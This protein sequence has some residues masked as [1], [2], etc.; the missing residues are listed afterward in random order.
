MNRG[1][2]YGLALAAILSLGAC[3]G[4]G[5]YTQAMSGHFEL[6]RARQDIDEYLATA[7]LNDPLAAR[8]Q[9][10]REITA[11]SETHLDLPADGSYEQFARLDRAAVT[12]NV[13]AAPE[14]SLEPKTWCFLV[15]GCVP[16]RGY[17]E[18]E[19]AERLAVKLRSKGLDVSVT[20][21]AAYSTLGWFDDPLLDTVLNQ[22]DSQLAGTLI[23]ELAHQRLYVRGD[24]AFNESYAAFVEQ[25]GVQQWL[26]ATGR[27]SA[28]Q[29]W[30]RRQEAAAWF[31]RRTTTL[32]RE[33][34]ALYRSE[35][36]AAKMRAAKQAAFDGMTQDWEDWRDAHPD[37]PDL[38][39]AWLGRGLNNAD[40]ALVSAYRSGHCAFQHLLEEAEGS[41]VTFHRLADAQ[42][43][44]PRADR[45]QWRE[46]ACD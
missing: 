45:R 18:R 2:A 38:Y 20:P 24:T 32:R 33:L 27:E 9:L 22:S 3:V 12:W 46:Q 28:S 35:Q 40:L 36:P 17:F 14:F 4:P 7:P 8:L 1:A 15:A 13:V 6:M 19:K 31:S 26:Q 10:S 21:A 34:A 29:A 30:A 5:Y 25:A 41:F 39:G 16:Y 23:H 44:R 11:W 37:R 42:S 43:R